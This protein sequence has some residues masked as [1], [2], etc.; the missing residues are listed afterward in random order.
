MTRKRQVDGSSRV[1]QLDLWSALEVAEDLPEE[2]DL[3][4]IWTSLDIALEALSVRA[5]L[6]LAGEA[7][8][9][10]AQIVQDRAWLTLSE[11][12]QLGS[13]ERPVMPIGAFDRFVRQSMQVN[14]EPFIEAPPV[15][16][17]M[18]QEVTAEFPDDGRSVVVELDQ[19]V[20][21]EVLEAD[22]EFDL[23]QTFEQAISPAHSE[24]VQEWNRAI[25]QCFASQPDHSMRFL[26][27]TSVIQEKSQEEGGEV[28]TIAVQTW[29]ALLLG[30]Y[31]LEQ[32][33]AFYQTETL[34]VSRENS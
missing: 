18:I 12:E 31:Q 6:K 9:R 28:G 10:L 33:G 22:V 26:E 30:E 2:A 24:N 4:K 17:R 14:F 25:Q 7:I 13:T 20:L 1:V 16:P 3:E 27:L 34:W 21:L 29:L 5:Q 11:L 19:A 15:P 23:P 32:R 8:A